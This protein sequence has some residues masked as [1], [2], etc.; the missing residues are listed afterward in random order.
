MQ[1]LGPMVEETPDPA[2]ATDSA[3]EK[4][5]NLNDM[6]EL[7]EETIF[8]IINRPPATLQMEN[9]DDSS[10]NEAV[11]VPVSLFSAP[12]MVHSATCFGNSDDKSKFAK[13]LGVNVN[14]IEQS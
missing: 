6:E 14:K 4:E 7:E 9:E 8:N 11:L 12:R 3:E 5:G 1:L 2:E 13:E 10:D